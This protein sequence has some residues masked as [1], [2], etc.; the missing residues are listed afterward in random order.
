MIAEENG[1][2][3]EVLIRDKK[4]SKSKFKANVTHGL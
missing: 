1:M 2:I 4:M 3:D